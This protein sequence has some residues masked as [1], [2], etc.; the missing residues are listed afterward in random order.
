[1]SSPLSRQASLAAA[2]LLAVMAVSCGR[3]KGGALDAAV[4]PGADLAV[5][6]DYREALAS[7]L[8]GKGGT[9]R[10]DGRGYAAAAGEE[11]LR[12]IEQAMGIGREDLLRIR[13][14]ADLD[15]LDLSPGKEQ[16]QFEKIDAVAVLA[17]GRTLT[18]R[19]LEEGV[20]FLAGSRVPAA[21]VG[22]VE[23]EGRAVFTVAP[24]AG[25]GY[26]VLHAALSREGSEV[27]LALNPASLREAFLR[28]EGDTLP[29]PEELKKAHDSLPEG[30]HLKSAMVV[31]GTVR[32]RIRENISKAEEKAAQ[33]PALGLFLGVITPFRDLKSLALGSRLDEGIDVEISADLGGEEQAVQASAVLQT[34]VVP[35]LK[36]RIARETGRRISDLDGKVAL[37]SRGTVLNLSLRLEADDLEGLEI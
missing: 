25:P 24:S 11:S 8:M 4:V 9:A 30:S 17:F 37:T 3:E 26:P 16:E 35:M 19:Q 14:S 28:E 20:R 5:T 31:P 23:I 32:G 29:L 12:G 15:P 13:L 27:F 10:S 21:S 7:P 1:M 18:P 22:R 34:I 2:V 33:N 6:I 36:A